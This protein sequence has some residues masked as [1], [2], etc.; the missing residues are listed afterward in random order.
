MTGFGRTGK[1]FAME[2]FGVDVDIMVTAKG[3]SGCYIPMGA[4]MVSDEINKP[5]EEGN[6]YFVHGFTNGGHP[7]ACAAG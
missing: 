1:W 4:V 2:H 3:I 5:F 6:A 7:V